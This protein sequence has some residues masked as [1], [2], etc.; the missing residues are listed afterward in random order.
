MYEYVLIM[1]MNTLYFEVPIEHFLKTVYRATDKTSNE[2][3]KVAIIQLTIS[4][5]NN[6]IKIT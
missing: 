4:D 2:F 6:A 3:Q 5:K 1:V